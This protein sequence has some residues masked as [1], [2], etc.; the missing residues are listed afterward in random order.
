MTGFD[1]L[2]LK[3]LLIFGYF[4]FYEQLKNYAQ[5]SW[6]WKKFYNIGARPLGYKTYF[7]LASAEIKNLSCS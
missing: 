7:M 6:A 3:L 2:N 1:N 4:S 5:L